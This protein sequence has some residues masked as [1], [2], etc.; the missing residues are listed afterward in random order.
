MEGQ[1][2]LNAFLRRFP[3]ARLAVAPESLRWRRGVFLRGLE[4]L[5]LV[6]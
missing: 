4:K 6:L 3:E 2:A 1:I 5:P